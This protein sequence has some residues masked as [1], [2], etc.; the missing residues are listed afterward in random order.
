[1]IDPLTKEKSP[2]IPSDIRKITI[3]QIDENFDKEAFE[4]GEGF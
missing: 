3:F 1:M 2:F 4:N